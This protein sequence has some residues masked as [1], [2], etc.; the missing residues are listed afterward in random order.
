MSVLLTLL[1]WLILLG[2]T[3][4]RIF[5][6][7]RYYQIEE[8]K[9]AR[10]ARWLLREQARYLPLHA[11][12]AIGL[13]IVFSV[14][15][16]SVPS[17]FSA[18]PYVACLIGAAFAIRPPKEAAVKKAFVT[19]ARAK[20]LLAGAWAIASVVSLALFVALHSLGLESDRI[21]AIAHLIAGFAVFLLAPLWLVLGNV[22]MTPI[23]AYLR[24]RF[25]QR[26]KGVL[27]SIQ[28]KI[29]GITGSYGKTTTKNF[30][31]DILNGR[32]KTYATPKS[33][34]TLMGICLAINNDLV[35][36]Y[37]IEYFISEMGAYIPGEIAR[38]CQL[39]P[40]DIS[41][42]VDVGP[43]HLERFGTL[44]NVAIAKYEIIKGVRPDGLGVF[45]WDNPHVREMYEKGYPANRIAVSK[46]VDPASV[47]NAS[48]RFIATHISSTLT[49]MAFT[50]HDALT[51]AQVPFTTPLVGEHNVMNLLL[52]TAVAVHEGMTLEAVAKR[53]SLLQPAESR[54]VRQ[55]DERGVLI[56]ND[57]YSANPVGAKSALQV[58]GLYEGGRRALITPGMI[59][60]GDL[61]EAENHKLG[62]LATQ[63]ATD[64]ILVGD[65]QTAPIQAGIR[66][67]GFPIERLQVVT[68]TNEAL[69]WY[70]EHLGRGDTVLLL[71][72]LPDTYAST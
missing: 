52:A 50:V 25:M 60:L 61:H 39:T 8:Y 59:E 40:P 19:T 67:T 36:D 11:L 64:I 54:L 3:V 10:Y 70:R 17:N 38:I 6:Q 68:H 2:G 33:Y 22:A 7:A 28:P 30:L 31:R 9:S 63:Y 45:N 23:E 37:S 72:D 44:E 62:V 12:V 57:A 35:D 56:I 55:H 21:T 49:G 51:G 26:A 5:K 34:N 71:N 14:I 42:V 1:L 15:G 66:S 16:D 58:L 20:R 65:K 29:I 27:A 48:P 18:L 47:Q 13:A 41:L 32:Y 46:E 4:W 24:R 69:A 53:V 43:Q